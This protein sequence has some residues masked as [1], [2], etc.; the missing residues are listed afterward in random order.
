MIA[1]QNLWVRKVEAALSF[2]S[3]T[4]SPQKLSHTPS[5]AGDQRTVLN[6]AICELHRAID[7]WLDEEIIGFEPEEGLGR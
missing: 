7:E 2:I 4:P 5:N 3:R 6:Y 1:P